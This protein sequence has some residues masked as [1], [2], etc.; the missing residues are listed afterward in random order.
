MARIRVSAKATDFVEGFN[1][2]VLNTKGEIKDLTRNFWHWKRLEMKLPDDDDEWFTF[3]KQPG[4]SRQLRDFEKISPY[5]MRIGTRTNPTRFTFTPKSGS[6]KNMAEAVKLVYDLAF[7]RALLV[8]RTG[9]YVRG[10]SVYVRKGIGRHN[11]TALEVHPKLLGSLPYEP[12]TV[13][14]IVASAVKVSRAYPNGFPYGLALEDNYVHGG[15][16]AANAQGGILYYAA[17]RLK[18]K[19]QR[20]G[21]GVKFSYINVKGTGTYPVIEI[22]PGVSGRS[23]R[24]GKMQRKAAAKRR[25]AARGS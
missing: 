19:L 7:Q 5:Y 21:V 15:Y 6:T 14:M 20:M 9:R 17:R 22:G 16:N 23:S 1:Q 2:L 13:V 3:Y 8:S 4:A 24:P 25:R 10:L 12:D 11:A 18:A